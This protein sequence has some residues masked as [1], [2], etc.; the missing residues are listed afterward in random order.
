MKTEFKTAIHVVEGAVGY[1]AIKYVPMNIAMKRF[2]GVAVG[3]V[4]TVTGFLM[5]GKVSNHV[6]ALGIGATI[7]GILDAFGLKR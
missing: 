7:G 2:N 4:V 5:P 1:N 3:S 6:V